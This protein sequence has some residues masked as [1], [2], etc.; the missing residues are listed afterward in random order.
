MEYVLACRLD[1]LAN[2]NMNS[3]NLLFLLFSGRICF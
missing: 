2:V 3:D 1:D